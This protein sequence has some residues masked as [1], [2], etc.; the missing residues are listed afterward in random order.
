MVCLRL[1]TIIAS[2]G[3]RATA[4]YPDT[5]GTGR[6]DAPHSG[7]ATKSGHDKAVSPVVVDDVEQARADWRA[8]AQMIAGGRLGEGR[9]RI[10]RR[11]ANGRLEYRDRDERALT[12]VLPSAPAAVRIYGPDGTCNSL[13]LDLDVGRGGRAQVDADAER[14]A[15]LL[16]RAGARAVTD[17]SPTGGRHVYVPLSRPLPFDEAVELVEALAA[18]APSLDASPH[19]SVLTGCIRV[20]GAVHKAGGHQQLTMSFNLAVDVLRRPN[21]PQVIAQLREELAP[22]IVARRARLAELAATSHVTAPLDERAA[23][24]GGLSPR[25]ARIARDGLYD[26]T[27]YKSPSEARQAVVAGAAAAGWRLQDVVA[28][29][30]DGRWP[31]L[32]SL[33]A[34]YR[35]PHKALAK[36]WRNAAAFVALPGGKPAPTSENDTVHRSNTSD[37]ETQGGRPTAVYASGGDDHGFIRTWRACVRTTEQH[38]LPGRKWY[39]ARFLLRAMGEAAHE[40]GSRRVAFGV[41]AL[42]IATGVDAS[43]VSVLLHELGRAGWID[44][45]EEGRGE[46]ADL[47]ELTIPH[48]LQEHAGE[49]RWDRGKVH[50]LRPAFRELGHV[51]ALA[52]EAVETGRADT[53]GT[54]TD[55]TGI[56]RRAVHEAVDVLSAWGLVER[57][58]GR[59]SARPGRLL[60]VAER[61]GALEAVVAQIVRYRAQREAWH[62][63]LR[64][65]DGEPAPTTLHDVDE[66]WW[67]PPDDAGVQDWTIVSSMRWTA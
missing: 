49:L 9:V 30:N 15:V 14:L 64:R 46:R 12:I 2:T 4:E 37:Q 61:L 28:R 29:L 26:A 11:V 20:P 35:D 53:V 22:Q 10:G 7:Q 41:R 55:A 38:R 17:R 60:T 66:D 44:R 65:H 57:T 36:D 33:Y 51:A 58:D 59:L 50:A 54:I 43:T 31:G 62:D 47:Y 23:G 6:A 19:R 13:C 34:R 48:D 24:R 25:L 52:F 63:Y 5:P 56:S 3:D 39:T 18:T 45:L 32:A 27:R 40:T 67:Y 8:C 42:A 21:P 16:E 1:E